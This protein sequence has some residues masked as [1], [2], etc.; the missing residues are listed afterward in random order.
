MTEM[1]PLPRWP[2][3]LLLTIAGIYFCSGAFLMQFPRIILGLGGSAQDVGWLLALGLIPALLLAGAVGEWNRRLGGRWPMLIGGLLAALSNA[4]MLTVDQVGIWML[5]LR[6]VF[7]VGH[8]MVFGTLFAQA[9]FLVDHP[10]QRAKL[11][12]WLAVVIQIGNAAGSA[13][14][15]AA[16]YQGATVFWF[17]AA[18]IGLVVV[19]LGVCWTVKPATLPEQPQLSDVKPSWPGEVWAIAAVG[20]AFA[21]VTQFLPAFIDYLGHSGAIAAP[22]AA[23]WFITPALLVVAL[24]RLVGGYFAAVL[25]RPWV[26]AICH[27]IL[28]LTLLL[29]PLMHTLHQAVWLGL[30]FGLSYG[31]LYP[32]LSALAFERVPAQERGRMAGWLVAAFEVGFRLSPIGLGALITH[33]GYGAMFIGLALAYAAVLLS[34][35]GVSSKAGRLASANI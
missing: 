35:W 18:G 19:V 25:L 12:G 7:A 30:A 22:F 16:Y 34:A 13:L 20:M 6:L 8:T 4:L 15:E 17:G 1:P 10:L 11:I 2:V 26:L 32:A 23:A 14:G 3:L 31:W 5:V 28:L 9:A 24:V 29:V 33:A 21:G 27:L